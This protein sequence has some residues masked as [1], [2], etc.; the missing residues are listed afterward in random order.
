MDVVNVREGK[1]VKGRVLALV[2]GSFGK[3]ILVKEFDKT[4]KAIVVAAPGAD[5]TPKKV[6]GHCKARLEDF[7]V[8]KIVEFQDALPKTENGKLDR[9]SLVTALPEAA[10]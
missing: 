10:E 1:N 8:P 4:V 2:L 6:I 5:L 9:R 7:M 3:R